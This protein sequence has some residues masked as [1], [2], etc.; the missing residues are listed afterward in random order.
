MLAMT[1]STTTARVTRAL[2]PSLLFFCLAILPRH[3]VF[4]ECGR[5]LTFVYEVKRPRDRQRPDAREDLTR[6]RLRPRDAAEATVEV[7]A[8]GDAEQTEKSV[9]DRFGF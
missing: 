4:S 6:V 7:T 3:E 2:F 1:T 8:P 5:V 9:G